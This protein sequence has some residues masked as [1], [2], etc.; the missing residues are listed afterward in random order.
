M[1]AVRI[2][3]FGQY[4]KEG[5][6][7]STAT[8]S[9]SFMDGTIPISETEYVK[10]SDLDLSKFGTRVTIEPS[11]LGPVVYIDTPFSEGGEIYVIRFTP[12]FMNQQEDFN[13]YLILL[14]NQP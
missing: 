13:R 14:R 12:E 5:T 4:I 7:S 11:G 6:A 2:P 8:V 10:Y 1:N 9:Y 3:S